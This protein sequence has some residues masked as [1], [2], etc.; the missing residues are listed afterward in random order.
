[1]SYFIVFGEKEITF[2]PYFDIE[3]LRE[4]KRMLDRSIRDIERER[5]QL[6]SQEKKLVAD[7]RKTAKAGQMVKKRN[8]VL[9]CSIVIFIRYT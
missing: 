6:Q 1:M 5:M 8:D 2:L 7:I 4:N 9:S 3:L